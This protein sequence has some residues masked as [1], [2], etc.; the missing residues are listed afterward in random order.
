M[1]TIILYS[2]DRRYTDNNEPNFAFKV[3]YS[4]LYCEFDE[5]G[6]KNTHETIVKESQVH[7]KGVEYFQYYY[8]Y[9]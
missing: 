7:L 4:D 2:C 6:R 5:D 8:K 3:P 9:L 1:S